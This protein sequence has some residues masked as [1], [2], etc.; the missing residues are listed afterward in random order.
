[1]P[2]AQ[3][4]DFVTCL[5]QSISSDQRSGQSTLQKS[6]FIFYLFQIMTFFIKNKNTRNILFAQKKNMQTRVNTGPHHGYH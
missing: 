4:C 2:K 5:M 3:A 1:V 6:I